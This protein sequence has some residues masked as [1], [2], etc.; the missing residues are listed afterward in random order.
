MEWFSLQL[1]EQHTYVHIF[2]TYRMN[3]SLAFDGCSV[4]LLH[5]IYMVQ[6]EYSSMF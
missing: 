4:I 1:A 5:V 3:R 6:C 2:G